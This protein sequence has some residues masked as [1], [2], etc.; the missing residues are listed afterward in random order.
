[1]NEVKIGTIGPDDN[2]WETIEALM[3][4]GIPYRR[5]IV[6]RHKYRPQYWNVAVWL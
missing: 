4:D 6:R 5:I 1:M 2:L 3:L